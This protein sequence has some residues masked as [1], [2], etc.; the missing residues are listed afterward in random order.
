[1]DTR[2]LIIRAQVAT[3]KMDR[4]ET[5]MNYAAKQLDKTLSTN[6]ASIL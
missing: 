6:A 1:M 4:F 3:E 5:A 2:C